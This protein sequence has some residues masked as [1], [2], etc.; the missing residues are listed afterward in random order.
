MGCAVESLW[1]YLFAAAVLSG[2]VLSG[3]VLSGFVLNPWVFSLVAVRDHRSST[4]RVT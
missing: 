4:G 1:L 3:F 2:F